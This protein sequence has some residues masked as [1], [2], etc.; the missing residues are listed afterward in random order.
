M[1]GLNG[2]PPQKPDKEGDF[3]WAA[4]G[5]LWNYAHKPHPDIV[6]VDRAMKLGFNWE[7]GRFLNCGTQAGVEATV[8]V[9][10][11]KDARSPRMSR[12]SWRL[13]IGLGIGMMPARHRGA[14][15]GI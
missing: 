5:D 2:N 10:K 8:E 14:H 15:I 9:V 3:L 7:M 1:L 6:E 12:S 13:E 11:K 4:L